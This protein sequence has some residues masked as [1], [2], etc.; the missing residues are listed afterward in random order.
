MLNDSSVLLPAVVFGSATFFLVILSAVF[1]IAITF[2][3]WQRK[4][5]KQ[6]PKDAEAYTYT[7]TDDSFAA[8]IENQGK[9]E[10]E[11]ETMMVPNNT[12]ASNNVSGSMKIPVGATVEQKEEVTV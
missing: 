10:P 8:D 1:I 12:D 11:V 7:S 2:V 6:K 5:R 3:L 4:L 9:R